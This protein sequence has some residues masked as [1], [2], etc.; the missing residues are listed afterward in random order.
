MAPAGLALLALL[1]CC[2]GPAAANY[3]WDGAEWKWQDEVAAGED[4]EGSGGAGGR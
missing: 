3:V 4:E 1:A 2:L